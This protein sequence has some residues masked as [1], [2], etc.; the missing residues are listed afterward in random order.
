MKLI[1]ILVMLLSSCAVHHPS[2][3]TAKDK[4]ALQT[5]WLLRVTDLRQQI[6]IEDKKGGE[7]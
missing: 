7:E 6:G 1:I 3:I 2:P 5:E 4:Q